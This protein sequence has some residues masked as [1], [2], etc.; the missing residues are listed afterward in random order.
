MEDLIVESKKFENVMSCLYKTSNARMSTSFDNI[1]KD[2]ISRLDFINGLFNDYKKEE[3]S[4]ECRRV[5]EDNIDFINGFINGEYNH[6]ISIPRKYANDRD[7]YL[8]IP[9]QKEINYLLDLIKLNVR[10]YD[11]YYKDNEIIVELPNDTFNKNMTRI[12]SVK[13]DKV[14]HLLGLTDSSLSDSKTS[15]FLKEYFKSIVEDTSVYGQG[16]AIALLNWIISDEGRQEILR[17]NQLLLNFVED[18]YAEHPA[19]YY[20][21]EAI[22]NKEKFSARFEAYYKDL[23]L[24]YPMI[25]FSRIFTKCINN[26]NFFNMSSI[27]MCIVDYNSRYSPRKYE[28]RY[29]EKREED[30]EDVD[31]KDFFFVSAPSKQLNEQ[32]ENHI[33]YMNNFL[34]K[35]KKYKKGDEKNDRWVEEELNEMGVTKGKDAYLNLAQTN[36]FV[37][38]NGILPEEYEYLMVQKQIRD[39]YAK[40]D[41]R[42]VHLIGFDSYDKESI[43]ELNEPMVHETHCDTSIGISTGALVDTYFTRGR[44][45]FLDKIKT[46]N[47]GTIRVSNPIE[48]MEYHQDMIDLGRDDSK[49]Y[50]ALEKGM[51]T[52][53]KRFKKFIEM[54][55]DLSEYYYDFDNIRMDSLIEP[56]Y[57]YLEEHLNMEI[58]REF[59]SSIL[60]TILYNETFLKKVIVKYKSNIKKLVENNIMFEDYYAEQIYIQIVKVLYK[61]YKNEKKAKNEDTISFNEFYNMVTKTDPNTKKKH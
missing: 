47:A 49:E 38:N 1:M 6:F 13:E 53:T 35:L 15:N 45:F 59:L 31:E 12:L 7:Q 14:A 8:I 28:D 19:S 36:Q 25:K 21:K 50:N 42:L 61:T 54:Q 51:K 24:K 27:N 29:K 58:D 48:E 9:S 18:D 37:E 32:I 56:S 57:I 23:G 5:F 39:Y 30:K 2:N 22:K 16:D 3:L 34:N 33:H 46:K 44:A 43:S 52:F 60:K 41:D 55:R 4:P 17:L 20:S 11:A 26:L 10:L 40:K